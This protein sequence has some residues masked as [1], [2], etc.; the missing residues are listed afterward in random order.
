MTTM[1]AWSYSSLTKFETCP[2]QYYAVRVSKEVTEPP[3]DA[4]LWGNAV[5]KA[6][7]LRVAE[8]KPLPK[9]MAQWEPLVNK[10]ICKPGRVF[11]ET[12]F[13]LTKG[14]KLTTWF[15]KDVWVRGIVDIGIDAGKKAVVL[16]WKTGKPKPDSE[17]LK[18]FAAFMFH[19]KPYMQQVSTGF[20]WLAHNKITKETYTR[21][22][23]PEIWQ[24]FLP[25]VRRL[26]LAYEGNKWE[27]RPSGLCNGWC[28]HKK[29]EFYKDKR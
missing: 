15:A 22:Q 13:A 19:S 2:R 12:K 27:P 17:Q 29:C 4:T 1:P 26:E 11:T 21:E 8:K 10:I 6:L 5:H 20:V 24:E 14:Y 18:L 25:R 3:T 28:P 9:T 16:D 7:E 23:L